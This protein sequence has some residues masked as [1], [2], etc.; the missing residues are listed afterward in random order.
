V[1]SAFDLN[2]AESGSLSLWGKSGERHRMFSEPITAEKVQL[3]EASGRKVYEWEVKPGKPDN[4]L[5]DCVV[6]CAVAASVCGIKTENEK[7]RAVRNA[8]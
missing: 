2:P 1:H 6:G 7:K 8:G 4:H 3:V 5:F